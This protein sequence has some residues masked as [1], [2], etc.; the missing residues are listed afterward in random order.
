MMNR[1][2]PFVEAVVAITMMM[3]SGSSV[4]SVRSGTMEVASR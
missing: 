2:K 3:S 4:T 1:V